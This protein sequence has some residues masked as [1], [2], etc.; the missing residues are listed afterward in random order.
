MQ[1][2]RKVILYIAMSLD[3]FIAKPDGNIDFL[4][5]VDQEGEDFGYYKFIETVDT[6][7]LG[8]KTYEKVL[9]MGYELPYPEKD[10]YILT[11]TPKPDLDTK[12]FYTGSLSDL[13]SKLKNTGGK[14]IYCD[15]GAETVHRL[16]MEDLIDEIIVSIIPVLLGDGISLFKNGFQEM[17]LQ[18][19]NSCA[20]EKGLVQL[21]YIRV[22]D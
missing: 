11:R 21:H 19:I 6:V 7:I 8:M 3:G 1:N 16:L 14:N 10:I 20:F 22:R 4:S 2:N 5:V 15:G 17:K 18:L 12:K 13:I 9:S